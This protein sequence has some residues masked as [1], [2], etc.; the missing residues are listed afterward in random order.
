MD[1]V[2]LS[3]SKSSQHSDAGR[4]HKSWGRSNWRRWKAVWIILQAT[5]YQYQEPSLSQ[6]SSRW[7]YRKDYIFMILARL[8][9]QPCPFC[10][11]LTSVLSLALWTFAS[12][13][14]SNSFL[15]IFL[16]KILSPIYCCGFIDT[17][18]F[19]S[20]SSTNIHRHLC[21]LLRSLAPPYHWNKF[22]FDLSAFDLRWLVKYH[23]H[24][25]LQSIYLGQSLL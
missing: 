16:P 13:G 6:C 20:T 3:F 15:K 18:K 2:I 22:S 19:A 25:A 11:E 23:L 17:F 5:S 1:Q 4:R 7:N 24:A 8:K 9:D 12:L 14:I 21:H 10:L